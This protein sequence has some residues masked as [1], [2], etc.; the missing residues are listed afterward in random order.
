MNP[1]TSRAMLHLATALAAI[2]LLV[3]GCGRK[4]KSSLA[5]VVIDVSPSGRAATSKGHGNPGEA[6]EAQR[7]AGAAIIAQRCREARTA[8][9]DL[10]DNATGVFSFQVMQV[11]SRSSTKP[12]TLF[13]WRELQSGAPQL[14]AT[15]QKMQE[16][17]DIALRDMERQCVANAEVTSNSPIHLAMKEAL[18]ALQTRADELAVGGRHEVTSR[19]L[20]V[21]SDFV[22]PTVLSTFSKSR[23]HRERAGRAKRSVKRTKY[24]ALATAAEASLRLDVP[25]AVHTVLC[26]LADTKDAVSTETSRAAW[27]LV[28]PN[29]SI[30]PSCR[31]TELQIRV[32][33]GGH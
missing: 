20:L 6:S 22:D 24:E 7:R 33:A 23:R 29:R 16:L 27:Q 3:G 25:A 32:S 26:G 4:P 31:Q 14:M 15:P 10:E 13:T 2:S 19:S 5:V 12:K 21:F 30:S 9:A 8:L 17:R 18:I 28:V 1:N 11:G